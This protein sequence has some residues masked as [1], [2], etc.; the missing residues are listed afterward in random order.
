M[1]LVLLS[2]IAAVF[3]LLGQIAQSHPEFCGISGGI[4]P[5]LPPDV[6]A[7]VT[8]DKAVLHIRRDTTDADVPLMLGTLASSISEIAEVCPLTDG[9]LV[10]FG[11]GW[12]ETNVHVV[13]RAKAAQLDSFSAYDPVLSP[14]QRW[15][16]YV[17]FGDPRVEGSSEYMIYDLSKTSQQNRPPDVGPTDTIN[18]GRVIFPPGHQNFSGGNIDLPEELRHFGSGRLFWAADSR[19]ILFED[20][21][22]G[23]TG[24]VLVTI[25]EKGPLSVSRH[26]LSA[27]E[28]C[29]RDTPAGSTYTW[30]LDSVDIR[31][32][33]AGN[34]AILLDLSAKGGDLCTPH[35]LQLSREDFKTAKMEKNVKPPY[36]RGAVVDGKE[37]TPPKKK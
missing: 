25:D 10:V 4:N 20:R 36:S 34:R 1:K 2:L 6:S 9:R 26:P 33:A 23:D 32:G 18:V 16:A 13:D 8:D 22:P 5:Q 14:D 28:I 3:P 30:K 35:V 37:V 29:G 11:K 24:I 7:T 21:T 17:K 27:S 31:P 12:W 15:I 19:A